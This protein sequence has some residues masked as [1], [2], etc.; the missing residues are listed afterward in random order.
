MLAPSL[1]CSL[2]P[3]K[4]WSQ[5]ATA[6]A[7]R[8]ADFGR[9]HARLVE[10]GAQAEG[11]DADLG[12][13][14]KIGLRNAADH[15]DDDILRQ[16]RA[17]RR[18]AFRRRARSPERI[19][20]P[21]RPTLIA[22]KASV[23]VNT[24]GMVTMRE[25]G[26][27]R[28]HGGVD[29]GADQQPA[30]GRMQAARRRRRSSTVPAPTSA[31]SGRSA[32]IVSIE[33][34]GSR[35]IERHLDRLDA[36]LEH[37]AADRLRLIGREAAQ[38]GDDAA[39]ELRPGRAHALALR[40]GV[41]PEIAAR[42]FEQ[43]V[44]H[45]RLGIDRRRRKAGAARALRRRDRRARRKRP[46]RYRSRRSRIARAPR[47]FR[48]RSAGRTAPPPRRPAACPSS[49][50]EARMRNRR[51]TA[52]PG[53]ASPSSSHCWKTGSSGDTFAGSAPSAWRRIECVEST[54]NSSPVSQVAKPATAPSATLTHLQCVP[55]MQ[56]SRSAPMQAGDAGKLR[57]LA[58]HDVGALAVA[59]GDARN[60]A[61]V[62]SRARDGD[63]A[64]EDLVETRRRRH[65][66]RFDPALAR[67]RHAAHHDR[68]R[69]G[70][71]H[72]AEMLLE[73]GAEA[74]ARHGE[75]ALVAA[76]LADDLAGRIESQ[77]R[78]RVVPQSTAAK[79]GS[80]GIRGILHRRSWSARSACGRHRRPGTAPARRYRRAASLP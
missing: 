67:A 71:A 17:D 35:R 38:D 3:A 13:V 7:A 60:D 65:I 33:R 30:A 74:F 23:G 14:G 79:A 80:E 45:G 72:R 31:L 39:L 20:A 43:A 16:H 15:A 27:A 21:R 59:L 70:G 62:A 64:G 53:C 12:I 51:E 76:P 36:G 11:A 26:G 40:A 37:G 19:S 58:A 4:T 63:R 42:R 68:Q 77:A 48:C 54:E 1:P 46:A 57:L 69:C 28:Q 50:V 44:A 9:A 47:R 8:V 24:P 75:Q 61:D 22:R 32:T 52:S 49:S 73:N 56:T 29:I 78:N 10:A 66:G 55:G 5:A 6:A 25:I 18:N 34:N 41:E 2:P